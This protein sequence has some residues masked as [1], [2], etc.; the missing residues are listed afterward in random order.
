MDTELRLNS[1]TASIYGKNLQVYNQEQGTQS[2]SSKTAN[3]TF[4]EI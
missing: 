3:I 1:K 4:V 2:H